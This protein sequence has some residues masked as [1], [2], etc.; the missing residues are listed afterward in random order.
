M[1]LNR[2]ELK[3]PDKIWIDMKKVLEWMTEEVAVLIIAVI[4]LFLAGVVGVYW[5]QKK[6]ANEGRAQYH[7]SLAK[8][9]SEQLRTTALEKDPKKSEQKVAER[10]KA[11][12]DLKKELGVLET[13]FKDS[14]AN[15]LANVLRGQWAAER[16]QWAEAVE[17]YARYVTSLKGEDRSLG[18]YP[19]GQAQEQS[20]QFDA[21]LKTYSELVGLK[22]AAHREWAFLGKARVLKFLKRNDEAKKTYE[23]FLSQF[24]NSTEVS[25]VRGFLASLPGTP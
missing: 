21:A 25:S 3:T 19:L 14:K 9:F 1:K 2:K 8:S 10:A 24:P 23:E 12:A 5:Y 13:D 16:G 20:G 22:N 15:Q 6:Q 11:E 18:L 7:Y 17:A 4:V